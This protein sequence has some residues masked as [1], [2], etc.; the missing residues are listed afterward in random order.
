VGNDLEAA[1][2]ALEEAT[3]EVLL[4]VKAAAYGLRLAVQRVGNVGASSQPSAERERL[5]QALECGEDHLSDVVVLALGDHFRTFLGRALKLPHPPPLPETPEES[6]TLAGTPGALRG[7]PFWFPLVLQLYRVVLQ[8]GRLDRWSF[9]RLG[10][11]DLEITFPGGKVK[12]FREGDRVSLTEGHL[13]QTADAVRAAAR[14][15]CLRLLGA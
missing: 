9:E 14:A 10:L 5:I 13:N 6:E 4:F 8:G 1:L 11:T 7:V 15:L 12:L 3:E 2:W